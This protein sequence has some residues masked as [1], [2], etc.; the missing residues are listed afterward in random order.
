M[1]WLYKLLRPARLLINYSMG[2]RCLSW[3]VCVPLKER[4]GVDSLGAE[5]A[6][7]PP[8]H[9]ERLRPEALIAPLY[10][11][12]QLRIFI[13]HICNFQHLLVYV[14]CAHTGT[15]GCTDLFLKLGFGHNLVFTLTELIPPT[16]FF[17][18]R[19]EHI[20]RQRATRGLDTLCHP[21]AGEKWQTMAPVKVI[22]GQAHYT[23][24]VRR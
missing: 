14:W 23:V 10:V 8:F 18:H 11:T 20:R 24:L 9:S 13:K 5:T 22:K 2:Q 7:S 1:F 4:H 17:G 15:G 16:L 21:V 12:K 19:Q 6:L 3:L